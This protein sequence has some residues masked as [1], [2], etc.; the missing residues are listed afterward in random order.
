M[1]AVTDPSTGA[2]RLVAMMILVKPQAAVA[3]ATA[4]TAAAPTG[5]PAASMPS[6][7]A[8]LQP[9]APAAA[10]DPAARSGD[11]RTGSAGDRP[12]N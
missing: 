12:R 10:T 3:P 7:E 9:A 6:D 1:L 5:P 8:L 2:D 11:R 4:A